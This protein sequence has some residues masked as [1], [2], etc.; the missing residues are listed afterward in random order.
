MADTLRAPVGRPAGYT[1]DSVFWDSILAD[2]GEQVPDLMYPASVLTYQQM[3]RDPQLAA[4]LRAFTL[5]IRRATWQIDPAGC[6]PEVAALVA[7]DLGL[8]VAGADR[9]GGARVR[10]VS[11][12]EHVRQALLQLVFGHMGFELSAEIRDGRARL[13]GLWERMP[14]SISAIRIHPDGSFAGIDQTMLPGQGGGVEIGA[15]RLVWYA[16]EREGAAWQGQSLLRPAFAPWLLKREMQRVHATSNRRFGTGVPNMQAMPGTNPTPE[17]MQAAQRAASAYRGGETAGMAT[18]P[19][20]SMELLGLSG[21][22][23]DTLGFMR[24]LDQQMSRMALAGFLDLG[25][26]PNGSRALGDS[27]ID[28]F[29]MSIQS[30]AESIADTATRQAAARVVEWNWGPDEPV[31]AVTVAD[32]GSQHAVTAE[33]LQSLMAAGA[34]TAD[35]ELEAYVRREYRLPPKAEQQVPAPA[36]PTPPGKQIAASRRRQAP[37]Q[38]ALPIAAAPGTDPDVQH[39][40]DWQQA[41][42][43]LQEAWD[44]AVAAGLTGGILAAILAALAAGGVA[45]LASVTA[46]AAA[47]SALADA[48]HAQMVALA[49]DGAAQA[50]AEVADQGATPPP[51]QADDETLRHVAEATAAVIAAGLV[52]GAVRAA[53]SAASSAVPGA[54]PAGN[55]QAVETAARGSLEGVAGPGSTGWVADNTG[56]ALTTAQAA[57]RAAV[58]SAVEAAGHTVT[59]EAREIND[60]AECEPCKAVGGTTYDSLPAALVDYPAGRYKGCLGGLRCRGR[61]VAHI[62]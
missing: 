55:T 42:D 45:G 14:S 22:T 58:F 4:I 49:A 8:P 60:A 15:E 56:A 38:M 23:P 62:H 51:A 17:Q 2:W 54:D 35:P 48:L 43:R 5:P 20:F 41:Q 6:R 24:W 27:F 1:D 34:L 30:I 7:D 26:T 61:L 57:G 3:R 31:P 21:G 10:G 11:W 19:G 12:S 25:D 40:Q 18:P 32:V 53:L 9:P 36:P 29:L 59:W 39:Q 13:T 47:V 33:S 16:H 50:A 28:L 44:T 37:G 52:N 46:P